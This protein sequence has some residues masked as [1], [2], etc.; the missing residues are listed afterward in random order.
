MK[1]SAE[2]ISNRRTLESLSDSVLYLH[3]CYVAITQFFKPFGK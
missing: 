3:L 1:Y 2:G